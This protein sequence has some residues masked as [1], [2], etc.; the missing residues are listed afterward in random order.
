MKQQLS[1]LTDR[2][3]TAVLAV[4]ITVATLTVLDLTKVN[5]ALPAIQQSLGSSAND[6]QLIVA[7]Y[8]LAFGLALVPAG[9]LGDAQSRKL[10][11]V[12]GVSLF[13]VA[14]VACALAPSAPVLLIA[15]LAQGIGAGI[16]MPQVFG[17]IQQLFTGATRGKAFGVLGAAL[18]SAIAV[19][20]TIGGLCIALGGA[21]DGWRWTFWMN[22]PLGVAVL[23]LLI[24]LLPTTPIR[25]RRA[26]LDP[27]GN[28]IFA[29]AIT[30]L[31][32]PFLS[33]NADTWPR[34]IWLLVPLSAILVVVFIRWER[35]YE[36]R[37]N[38]PLIPPSLF[39]FPTFRTGITVA[40]L[41]FTAL[42]CNILL[43]TLFLQEGLY[44]AP[45]FAGMITIGYAGAKSI[46]SWLSG[47]R[48][49]TRARPMITIG[50]AIML[51][52]SG[53]LVVASAAPEPFVPW[54]MA[55]TMLVTGAGGGMMV[56]ANQTLTL[57]EIPIQH[58]GVAASIG[59]LGQRIGGAVGL[60]IATSVYFGVAASGAGSDDHVALYRDS[61]SLAMVSVM[62]FF[63]VALIIAVRD[64]VMNGSRRQRPASP[65]IAIAVEE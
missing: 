60:A 16:Q 5:V 53:L 39:R 12:I 4:C 46:S 3:R 33:I 26:S 44:I 15:R 45:V 43:A 62:G 28:V 38:E 48:A 19:G 36:A 17:V 61:Y 13:T 10:W 52:G 51:L 31:L 32:V 30:A 37:G 65:V 6:L 54:A 63:A 11:F 49:G 8:V 27:V 64:Q 20:P 47:R 1:T 25:I 42:P 35:A 58:G 23:V 24:R 57:S 41:F 50:L 40:T 29:A 22:V 34:S 55:A 2:Q 18:G 14:S 9:R 7:G 21:E 59:Q 56:P